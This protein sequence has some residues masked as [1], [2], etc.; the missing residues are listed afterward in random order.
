MQP[1]R[2]SMFRGSADRAGARL[3]VDATQAAGAVAIDAASWDA[4]VVVSSG[5][6]W[7]GGHGGVALAVM[8]PS[9]LEHTPPL[10][11]WMG[12]RD[13]FDFD[14]KQVLLADDARR[15][16]LSTMSY[17]SIAALAASLAQ[18]LNLG[19]ASIEQHARRLAE[20]LIERVSERGWTP[21]RDL[22]D[23]AASPH[24]VSL[25]RP[26]HELRT[27]LHALQAASIVCSSRGGRVRVSLAPYNDESD[28]DA[29]VAALG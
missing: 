8:A 2:S 18:L 6:K 16:T 27:T 7:L 17:V 21:F 23:P 11:G 9:L 24:I 4:D 12:A 3:V 15:Y 22:S 26:D 1:E 29:L 14:A 19:E 20:R 28:I 13:P 25:T 5:Y 10:P